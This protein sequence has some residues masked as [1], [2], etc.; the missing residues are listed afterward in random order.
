MHVSAVLMYVKHCPLNPCKKLE[1]HKVHHIYLGTWWTHF[2][3]LDKYRPE[4]YR[5]RKIL[6]RQQWRIQGRK[7][8][9]YVI[10]SLVYSQIIVYGFNKHVCESFLQNWGPC[11]CTIHALPHT[12]PAVNIPL[13]K[14]SILL[15]FSGPKSHFRNINGAF[16]LVD[17][18][19]VSHDTDISHFTPKQTEE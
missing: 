12:V 1:R 17:E 4:I 16:W 10:L 2:E 3:K 8:G 18:G 6:G 19:S 7:Y 5:R 9:M 13:S 14:Y 11:C 15:F